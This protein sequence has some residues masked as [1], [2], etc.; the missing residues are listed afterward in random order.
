MYLIILKEYSLVGGERKRGER[1]PPNQY[2][3]VH[4]HPIYC[5]IRT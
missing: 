4:N 5:S 3:W 2:G 1:I